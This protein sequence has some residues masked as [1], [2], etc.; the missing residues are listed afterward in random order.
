M[1]T[2][3]KRS[4]RRL[5]GTIELVAALAPWVAGA[6]PAQVGADEHRSP[7]VSECATPRAGWIW[8]DDFEQDRLGKYFEYSDAGGNFVRVA[9]VGVGGSFGMRA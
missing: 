5:C 2:Q 6:A 7:H 4:S 1:W 9:G 3:L 8:C